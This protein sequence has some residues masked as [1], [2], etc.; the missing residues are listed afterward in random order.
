[1]LS[2]DPNPNPDPTAALASGL[3][4]LGR[5]VLAA[6]HGIQEGSATLPELLFL[7]EAAESCWE[8]VEVGFNAGMSAYALLSGNPVSRLI[9]FDLGEWNCVQPAKGYIDRCFP[10]RHTLMLGNSKL[11]LPIFLASKSRRFDLAFIDGGH[12]FDTAISDLK[13]LSVVSRVLIADDTHLPG[14]RAAWDAAVK[15]GFIDHKGYFTSGEAEYTRQWA[16]GKSR[17]FC[18]SI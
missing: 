11:I 10:D 13:L 15:D 16:M 12:D 5:H 17:L 8:M 18:E 6:G 3:V 2:F 9:S 1:M 7:R 4:E 14:P